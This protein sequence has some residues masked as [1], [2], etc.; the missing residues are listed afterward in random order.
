[1]GRISTSLPI[2]RAAP[3]VG[4]PRLLLPLPLDGRLC[5]F[6]FGADSTTAAMN[7]GVQPLY[8]PGVNTCD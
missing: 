8:F 2:A 1:M 7:V 6:Q 3:C 5:H 4:R